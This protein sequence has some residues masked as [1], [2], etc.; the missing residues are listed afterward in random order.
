MPKFGYST[1]VPLFFLKSI[2]VVAF[3]ALTCVF[4]YFSWVSS[5]LS[6]Q[7]SSWFFQSCGCL[8]HWYTSFFHTLFIQLKL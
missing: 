7:L 3:D 4:V 6:N 2:C 5:T 1:A 8:L